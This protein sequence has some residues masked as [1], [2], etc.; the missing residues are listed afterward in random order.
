V[1]NDEVGNDYLITE[2]STLLS[3]LFDNLRGNGG[4]NRNGIDGDHFSDVPSP[5]SGE[6]D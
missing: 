6:I 4:D 5:L 1:P 3:D 2:P